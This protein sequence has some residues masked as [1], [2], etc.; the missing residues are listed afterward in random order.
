MGYSSSIEWTQTTWNPVTG[1][2]QVSPGCDHCY[3]LS[4]AERF[5][6]VSG[7]PYE[8]GFD[9]QLRPERLELP[10]QWRKPRLIFVNSMSDLFHHQVPNQF[11]QRVFETMA[12]ADR[13]TFQVLT[14]RPQRA[15]RM[16]RELPWPP[17]VWLGT[18]VESAAYLWRVDALRPVPAAI[19]FLSCEPLLGSLA[20]LDLTR[21]GWVI[22][23]G[24]SGFGFR[25]PRVE[26]LRDLRDMCLAAKLPFF[27][28]QWGGRYPKRGGRELDG[29]SWDEMP[30]A[31]RATEIPESPVVTRTEAAVTGHVVHAP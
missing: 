2:T 17:N 12:S 4:F 14:K 21:I 16:S 28:K 19:R 8:H 11:I 13:H 7:H 24:E 26:W 27:F 6:G 9:L 10:L 25:P 23:G 3:A 30:G 5:R 1:C 31:A 18:S 29:R 20:G 22:A 15:L